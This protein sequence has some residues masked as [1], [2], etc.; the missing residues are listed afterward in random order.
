[1]ALELRLEA[2]RGSP[3]AEAPLKQRFTTAGEGGVLEAPR[4]LMEAPWRRDTG[5]SWRTR[6]GFKGP[7]SGAII[8]GRLK[9][10][11]STWGKTN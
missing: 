6:E 9:S 7:D 8:A 11:E 4:Q 10:G 5:L 2:G 3:E 1:M